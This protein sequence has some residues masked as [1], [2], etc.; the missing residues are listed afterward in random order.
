MLRE[1]L[2]STELKTN[3]NG[4]QGPPFEP[5]LDDRVLT[6]ALDTENPGDNRGKSQVHVRV[7]LISP[8]GADC[9]W[10]VHDS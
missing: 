6:S 2:K 1:S 4:S 5:H 9:S 3:N 8:V 10:P 7:M